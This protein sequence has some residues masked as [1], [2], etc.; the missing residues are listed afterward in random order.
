MSMSR[1]IPIRGFVALTL[2][3]ISLPTVAE[4]RT[5]SLF[6]LPAPALLPPHVEDFERVRCSAF[7]IVNCL[8][9]SQNYSFSSCGLDCGNAACERLNAVN[10]PA[11]HT[12][13]PYGSGG[14]HSLRPRSDSL[15]GI[16]RHKANAGGILAKLDG[17]AGGAE[18]A[19][20]RPHFA[21]QVNA[22]RKGGS[23]AREVDGFAATGPERLTVPIRTATVQLLAGQH[24]GDSL[25]LPVS[26]EGHCRF[27]HAKPISQPILIVNAQ[28]QV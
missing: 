17:N 20:A 9:V 11:V 19:P 15:R 13:N 24:P 28:N 26:Q 4:I 16:K 3:I 27:V 2:A 12:I 22:T 21:I 1:A 18:P 23:D 8:R 7:F 5:R 14:V 6:G 10:Y 25:A